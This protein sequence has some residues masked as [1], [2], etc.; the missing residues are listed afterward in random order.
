MEK[1]RRLDSF[2]NTG[3]Q[4]GEKCRVGLS[5]VGTA[6]FKKTKYQIASLIHIRYFNMISKGCTFRGYI[7]LLQSL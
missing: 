1:S 5:A 4:S 6:H 3:F 7:A 2:Y